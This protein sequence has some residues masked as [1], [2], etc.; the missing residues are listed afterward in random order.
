MTTVTTTTKMTENCPPRSSPVTPQHASVNQPTTKSPIA[1]QTRSRSANR[2]EPQ[3]SMSKQNT[4]NIMPWDEETPE[5]KWRLQVITNWKTHPDAVEPPPVELRPHWVDPT[6]YMDVLPC[7]AEIGR[8]RESGLALLEIDDRCLPY[9]HSTYADNSEDSSFPSRS[10]S[11]TLLG[12]HSAHD[13]L[14]KASLK[15]YVNQF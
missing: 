14:S 12:P 1:R 5:N 11:P 8:G 15:Q 7:V 9:N 2:T 6:D 4:T 3:G 13:A 10:P